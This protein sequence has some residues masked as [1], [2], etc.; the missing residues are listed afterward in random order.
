MRFMNPAIWALAAEAEPARAVGKA[1]AAR[2]APIAQAGKASMR[3]AV[4]TDP[5]AIAR[6][7]F[8]SL[9]TPE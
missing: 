5:A 3:P 2:D 1:E 8:G 7:P 6:D 4:A 9:A